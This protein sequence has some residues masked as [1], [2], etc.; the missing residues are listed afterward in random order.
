[1]EESE[2]SFRGTNPFEE[3]AVDPLSI[4]LFEPSARPE[5]HDPNGSRS[6]ASS[7]SS[8]DEQSWG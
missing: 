3:E 2:H 6:F 8:T 1:M 4:D 5:S 7:N